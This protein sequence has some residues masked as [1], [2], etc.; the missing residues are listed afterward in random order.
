MKGRS[1][2]K[3]GD[4]KCLALPG[5]IGQHRCSATGTLLLDASKLRSTYKSGSGHGLEHEECIYGG[6]AGDSSSITEETFKLL[7]HGRQNIQL[8]SV[9]WRLKS[10]VSQESQAQIR[11]HKSKA[12]ASLV[13][14][15]L[16]LRIPNT[17]DLG[18]IPGQGIRPRMPQLRPCAAK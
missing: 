17:G 13:V 5:A 4:S 1:C 6:N 7:N 2:E 18:S 8:R 3:T 15:R 11:S 14:Q 16:R 10:E 9:R 12:G